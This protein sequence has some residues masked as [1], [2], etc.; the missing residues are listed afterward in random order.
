MDPCHVYGNASCFSPPS[1]RAIF[2]GFTWDSQRS[3]SLRTAPSE[4]TYSH[5]TLPQNTCAPSPI[6]P[7]ASQS[8]RHIVRRA[9]SANGA[10]VVFSIAMP[11]RR[12]TLL[13]CSLFGGNL[14]FRTPF[15]MHRLLQ[16]VLY[17]P[18]CY[19]S[20]VCAR[21]AAQ[22]P[23]ARLLTTS[24]QQAISPFPS[25]LLDPAAPALTVIRP[26]TLLVDVAS[27]ETHGCSRKLRILLSLGCK[28]V[29]AGRSLSQV[30]SISV[31]SIFLE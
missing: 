13:L 1:L 23:N 16:L 24:I 7:T 8:R 5:C 14:R 10:A 21:M 9:G 11:A 27:A 29:N 25:V 18:T 3:C 17:Y 15:V 22:C 20:F 28:T 4:A 19:A 26:R 2:F 6:T 31:L 30:C 12:P